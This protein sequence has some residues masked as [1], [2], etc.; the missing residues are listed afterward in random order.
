MGKKNE[1]EGKKELDDMKADELKMHKRYKRET[2]NRKDKQK[3][4]GRRKARCLSNKYRKN[5]KS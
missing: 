3:K 4:E 5:F 2:V 1:V